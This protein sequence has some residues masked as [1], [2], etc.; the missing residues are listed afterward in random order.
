VL[1][2]LTLLPKRIFLKNVKIYFIKKCFYSFEEYLNNDF[3]ETVYIS[4]SYFFFSF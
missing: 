1:D 3:S 2:S 4:L